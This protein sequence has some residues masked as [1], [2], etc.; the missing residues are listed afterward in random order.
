MI[1]QTGRTGNEDGLLS[2]KL[3]P[4]KKTAQLSLHGFKK[5]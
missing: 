1:H 4:N 2:P 5:V 3:S